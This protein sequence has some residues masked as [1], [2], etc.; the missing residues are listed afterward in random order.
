MRAQSLSKTSYPIISKQNG[1]H[2][3]DPPFRDDNLRDPLINE[4]GSLVEDI[5]MNS[6]FRH[7]SDV[8]DYGPR[9]VNFDR[10]IP[11][12]RQTQNI[13]TTK[14]QTSLVTIKNKKLKPMGKSGEVPNF[15]ASAGMKPNNYGVSDFYLKNFLG[16]QRIDTEERKEK[17]GT[18]NLNLFDL[19]QAIKSATLD[20][21]KEKITARQVQLDLAQLA[22]GHGGLKQKFYD[23]LGASYKEFYMDKKEFM[24]IFDDID[25]A[26]F[27][28]DE[29]R[30]FINQI[31]III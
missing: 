20:N 13:V 30:A 26:V 27:C 11:D 22:S 4:K 25:V 28:H 5:S 2:K 16:K 23:S 7:N 12:L 10:G 31:A 8:I 17:M 15:S 21:R 29:V 6:T 9:H 19:P 3:L 1:S 24:K 18:L 14:S